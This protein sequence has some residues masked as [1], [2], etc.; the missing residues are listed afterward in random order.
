LIG[1][2][3]RT[4]QFITGRYINRLV[5]RDGDWRIAVRWSTVEGMCIAEPSSPKLGD[6]ESTY[7]RPPSSTPSLNAAYAPASQ[8]IS[9][10]S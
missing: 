4:A 10:K 3:G 9:S 7:R 8:D 2:G 1:T 6:V 5:R